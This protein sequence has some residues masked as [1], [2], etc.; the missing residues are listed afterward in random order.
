[1]DEAA[2]ELVRD[3]LTRASHDLQAARVLATADASHE[4]WADNFMVNGTFVTAPVL[5]ITHANG[6]PVL[7]LSGDTGRQYA[8]EYES[9]LAAFPDWL[10]LT[11]LVLTNSSQAVSDPSAAGAPTRYYRARVM[12]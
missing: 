8:I 5:R 9:T 3:W 10:T 2:T 6:T 7:H 4:V 12:P 1:M 11:N